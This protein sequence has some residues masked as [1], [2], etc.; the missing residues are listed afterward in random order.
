MILLV[1]A[2]PG[3]KMR[4]KTVVELAASAGF[5]VATRPLAL[6]PKAATQLD[7]PA[8]ER[9]AGLAALLENQRDWTAAAIEAE[10][11]GFAEALGCKL[12][13]VAQPLR[14]AL[15]GSTVSP[16]IF[17]VAELLGK[18]ETLLRVR[19]M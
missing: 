18:T 11:R 9:L 5:Y 3:L 2:M 17:E 1:R 6:E 8:R 4:A 15:T 19:S 10:A 7:G 12:G 16:P 13:Q 14:A